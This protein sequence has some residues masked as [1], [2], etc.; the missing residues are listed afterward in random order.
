MYEYEKWN[1]IYIG[2][3]LYGKRNGR[4]SGKFD[5]MKY[6]SESENIN[7]FENNDI[8][9]YQGEYEN[10]KITGYGKVELKNSRFEGF[11]LNGIMWNGKGYDCDKVIYELK[12][13]KGY[14]KEYKFETVI[15]EGEYLFGKRNGK[16]KEYYYDGQLRFEGEY[17][18]DLEWNGKGYNKEDNTI[19]YEIK[20]GTGFKKEYNGFGSLI[21]EGNFL[22]GKRQGKG[23]EY[24]GE[25]VISSGNYINDK[26]NGYFTEKNHLYKF[27]GEYLNNHKMKG[28]EYIWN[29]L[30]YEGEYL[31]GTKWHG[32]GYDEKGNI[33]YEL[34]N[35]NGKVKEYF[36]DG[37]DIQFE[38]EYKNGIK[39]GK[40][41]IYYRGYDVDESSTYEG[42]F[43][44]GEENGKGKQYCFLNDEI[45]EG[46]FLN[47]ERKKI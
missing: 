31:N 14:V 2:N 9:E 44:Y 23:T 27:E 28:K 41:K 35:G 13:G 42:D 43:L 12:N 30:V 26:K 6:L 25:D 17:K 4:G 15:F 21:F 11:F 32:K 39:N 29:E 38:G 16:G 19:A 7:K 1:I 24:N 34:I 47:G 3:Y 18:N 36:D 22:D 33:E 5:E 45:Y 20:N 46:E 10:G 8:L 37:D 40:G